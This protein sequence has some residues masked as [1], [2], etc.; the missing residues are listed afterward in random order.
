[1]AGRTLVTINAGHTRRV[2]TFALWRIASH[3]IVGQH[4]LSDSFFDR[5]WGGIH[6]AYV[7]EEEKGQAEL[8]LSRLVAIQAAVRAVDSAS[9][10]ERLDLP[11]TSEEL[12]DA[13]RDCVLAIDQ[14]DEL[15]WG[16]SPSDQQDVAGCRDAAAR[17]L[18]A[19]QDESRPPLPSDLPAV[20]APEVIGPVV[21]KRFNRTPDAPVTELRPVASA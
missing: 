2:V 1:M 3:E 11:V 20:A 12:I 15:F 10:G 18:A 5:A 14:N 17:L 8:R 19:I 6:P 9:D 21:V 13:L 7:L 4:E 16:L